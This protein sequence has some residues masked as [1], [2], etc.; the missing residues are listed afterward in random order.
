MKRRSTCKRLVGILLCLILLLGMLPLPAAH[1]AEEDGNLL[2][3]VTTADMQANKNSYNNAAYGSNSTVISSQQISYVKLAKNEHEGFQ[4][5]VAENNADGNGVAHSVRVACTPFTNDRGDVLESSIYKEM[6]L[7][8]QSVISDPLA[9]V[10]IPYRGEWVENGAAENQMFYV[11]LYAAPDQPAGEYSS[12]IQVYIDDDTEPYFTKDFTATVWRFALPE[13][14]YSTML[15]GLYNT[16]SGYT[17]TRGFLEGCGVA[18]ESSGEPVQT[19]E[20]LALAEAVLEG[21]DELMLEHGFNAYEIPRYLADNDPKEAQLAMADVRRHYVSVPILSYSLSN[22]SLRAAAAEKVA[23]Y[24]DLMAISPYL[25]EKAFFYSKD[26][27]GWTAAEQADS[28]RALVA[29]LKEVWTEG[30]SNGVPFHNLVTYNGAGDYEVCMDVFRDTAD[31]L[32]FAHDMF[33]TGQ[34]DENLLRNRAD[35][36]DGSWYKIMRYTTGIEAGSA[37]LYR[38]K[39]SLTGLWRRIYFWQQAILGDDAMLTW[40]GAW[41]GYTGGQLYNVWETGMLPRKNGVQGDNGDGVLLY[42]AGQY[43]DYYGLTGDDAMDVTKPLMSLRFKQLSAGIDEYDYVTLA[44][45]VLGEEAVQQLFVT[46]MVMDTLRTTG[47]FANMWPDVIDW[48][49]GPGKRTMYTWREAFGNALDAAVADGEIHSYGDWVTVVEPDATHNGL[50]IRTCTCCG[51]R[52]SRRTVKNAELADGYYLASPDWSFGA[53]EAE[54]RFQEDTD[55]PGLYVLTGVPLEEGDQIWAVRTENPVIAQWYPAENGAYTVDAA[56]AGVMTVYF[57]ESRRADWSEFGG[58]LYIEA[59]DSLPFIDVTGSDYFYPA[60]FWAYYQRPKLTAGSSAVTF[61]PDAPCTRAQILSFL[62]RAYG[63]PRPVITETAFED[64]PANAWYADALLWAA[65]RR[66]TG[67]TSPNRFSP[68][69]SCTRAQTVTFLWR[70][71]GSPAPQ[72]EGCVFTD[73]PAGAWYYD[74]VRWA[75]ENGV[76]AGTGPDSF[77]PNRVCT[78]AEVLTILY[79]AMTPAAGE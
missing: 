75:A 61:S 47:K 41:F 42:P 22:G 64:V 60:V 74:A 59:C 2:I 17:A 35:Y 34:T 56:H 33:R 5:Y 76:V 58:H 40:N 71:A 67:G 78:R 20:N 36:L 3:A 19:P 39:K 23:Q 21:W 54:N 10:L 62:W 1:A 48:A 27:A 79:A 66:I 38:Y 57:S 13:S 45:E 52:Q 49:M 25:L 77:S 14:H 69:K 11:D 43:N 51:T 12:E 29:A 15:T 32:V 65:A 18:F 44:R 50:D 55:Q 4:I 53:I 72:T 28:Y 70:A 30:D 7:S 9:D 8:A 31:I 37:R 68:K 46:N 24:R 16:A 73:V 26:E 63:S 6:Y